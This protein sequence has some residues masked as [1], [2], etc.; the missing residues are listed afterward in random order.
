MAEILENEPFAG[1]LGPRVK[2][3]LERKGINETDQNYMGEYLKELD[4]Q[5]SIFKYVLIGS[6]ALTGPSL[7]NKLNPGL[8]GGNKVSGNL[9]TRDQL[10]QL[11]TK[12]NNSVDGS[13]TVPG[14]LKHTQF[15]NEIRNL[16]NPLLRPEVTYK[17]GKIEPYGTKGGVRLDAVEY[18]TD[19]TIKAIYDLKTGKAGLTDKRIQDIQN[20]LPNSAPVYEIKP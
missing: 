6:A 13:G 9:P 19:G 15:A 12:A 5:R 4:A 1:L 14:T 8:I 10:Q 7:T 16:N 11:A 2:Y 17:N 3:E 20:H 18:N